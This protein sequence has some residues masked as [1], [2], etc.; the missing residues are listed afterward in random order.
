MKVPKDN[1]I[2]SQYSDD[3]VK[4][5][6]ENVVAKGIS[7]RVKI[8]PEILES[9]IKCKQVGLDPFTRATLPIISGGEL[10]NLLEHNSEL[11]NIS[12]PVIEMIE[13]SVRE[14]GFIITLTEKNGHVLLLRGDEDI[15]EMA[16]TNLFLPGC[17]RTI[18]HAGTNAIGMCLILKKPIQIT[19]AEHYKIHHHSW[20]CS[21]SPIF[22]IQ[23]EL[24]GVITLSGRSIGKHKHTLALVTD[25]AKNIESRLREQ[26]LN[27]EKQRLDSILSSIFHSISGGLIAVDDNLKITHINNTAVTMLGLNYKSVIG[28]MFEDAIQS[29]NSLVEALKSKKYFGFNNL[30]TNFTTHKGIMNYICSI[31][32]TR[33][34][35]DRILGALITLSEKRHFINVAKKVVGNYAKYHFDDIKGNDSILLNQI[36]VAK[37][38]AKTESRVLIVSE[39]GTGKELFAQSIHNY[40]QRAREPFVAI[41]CAA[42]PRDLIESELFGYRGG[43]F[44]GARREGQIGK[45]ELAN[46]GTL[47]LDEIGGLPLELQAKLLRVL[48]E[49]EV[50]R[51]GDTQPTQIDVRIIAAS[52]TDL[53][54]KIK[55]YEFREDLYYRLSTIEIQ[56]PP[57]R[58]RIGDLELLID[59]II[60]RICRKN[61]VGGIKISKTVIQ[62]LKKYDWP[63]NVRQLENCIEQAVLFS[64]DG[65]INETNLP[66]KKSS[67]FRG[68]K[69]NQITLDDG[70]KE[71]V[72]SALNRCEGNISLAARELQISRSTLYRKIRESNL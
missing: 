60:N 42:I 28:R 7:P 62:R 64:K 47:F 41:S 55:R 67:I 59:H 20:T 46:Q 40:S 2:N 5:A 39:T 17:L 50:T 15:L 6:W 22:N 63:G 49:N 51:L 66:Y 19:G 72:K 38:A 44:T 34:C 57:L 9:W 35:S 71:I 43:A 18:E 3:I 68:F 31:D 24:I 27:K 37:T 14:T 25:A 23:N 12:L 10:N 32:P 16:E 1:H 36:E 29:E 48:Q 26:D 13:I 53:M 61:G 33:D 11:V 65:I 69:Q 8:R 21:S 30:E 54:A 56:I 45:F 52:N 58:E 70:L 4:A